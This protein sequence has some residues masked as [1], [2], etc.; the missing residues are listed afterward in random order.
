MA[1]ITLAFI[2]GFLAG[3]MF[4]STAVARSIRDGQFTLINN[5]TG[6]PV[7]S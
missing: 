4:A 2:T 1:R 7:L 3:A 6:E 5:R